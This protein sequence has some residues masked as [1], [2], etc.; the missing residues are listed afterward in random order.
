MVTL[1]WEMAE[2]G[3]GPRQSGSNGMGS[4]PVAFTD[5]PGASQPDW[6]HE[7][8]KSQRSQQDIQTIQT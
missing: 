8:G 5:L 7:P 2:L 3:S 4:L 6:L 1:S